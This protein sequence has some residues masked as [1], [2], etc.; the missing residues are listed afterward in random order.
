M[1]DYTFVPEDHAAV[2]SASKILTSRYR[3]WVEYEDVQQECYL[4]LLSN[5]DKA[6]R[7]RAKYAEDP[8]RAERTVLKAL[9]R[10]GE[11]Y[12]RKEKA[13]RE[14][15]WPEDEFFYSIPMVMKL[16]TLHFDP[17][18]MM[19]GSVVYDN[20]SSGKPASEGGNLIAMVADVG[21]AY[22][23]LSKH[24]RSLLERVYGGEYPVDEAIASEALRWGINHNAADHRIRRVVGRVRAHLGGASPYGKDD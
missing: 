20:V 21:K 9:R 17:T 16:L 15:F 5:Y 8:V 3:Q 18:W 10:N 14:G 12:C 11:R 1:T 2:Q 4:W 6:Q 24:D 7:Y 19:P 13:A 23:R 22:E